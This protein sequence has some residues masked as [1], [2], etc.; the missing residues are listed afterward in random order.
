MPNYCN[1]DIHM[2]GPREKLEKLC[3]WFR[4]DYRYDG[5][6]AVCYLKNGEETI[7]C[8]HHIGYR[9]FS[10]D[11]FD[12]D[13]ITDLSGDSVWYGCGE[14]AWSCAVC[15]FEGE[16]S[17]CSEEEDKER[18]AITLPK[19]CAELGVEVE[20]F[21][22][23]PGMAFAEHYRIDSE[24]KILCDECVDWEE[25]ELSDEEDAIADYEELCKVLKDKGI[26]EH[27]I[28][29]NVTKEDFDAIRNGAERRYLY[30]CSLYDD[31][32]AWD[33]EMGWPWKIE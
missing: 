28:A 16:F 10:F 21:S 26:S 29:S 15:M 24:G 1:F 20:L 11:C 32:I 19:A 25:I 13:D 31:N 5:D 33:D 30:C 6:E 4:A 23:E 9:V 3:Q 8:E 18:F 14:C 12:D 27:G 2:S 7:P 17:Y 22:N